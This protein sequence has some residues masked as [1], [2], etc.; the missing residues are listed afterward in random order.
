MLVRDAVSLV[1]EQ[2]DRAF[3]GGLEPRQSHRPFGELHGEYPPAGGALIRDP[4]VLVGGDPVHARAPSRSER[5]TV[6]E[7][8]SV[9]RAVGDCDAGA[10]RVA[11]P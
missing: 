1:A 5:V 3:P 11:G 10:D 9:V 4:A 7:R 6:P 8:G 2:D